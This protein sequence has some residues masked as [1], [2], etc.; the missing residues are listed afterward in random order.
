MATFNEMLIDIL[1]DNNTEEDTGLNENADKLGKVL[2]GHIKYVT[3]L[4]SEFDKK[5]A[6]TKAANKVDGAFVEV[7]GEIHD[8]LLNEVLEPLESLREW[9]SQA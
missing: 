9:V 1:Q 3:D 6:I 7:C 2:D 5:G 8:N 4:V